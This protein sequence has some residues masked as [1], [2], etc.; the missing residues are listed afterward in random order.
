MFSKFFMILF[1][2]IDIL[3]SPIYPRKLS[4]HDSALLFDECDS[5]HSFNYTEEVLREALT[6]AALPAIGG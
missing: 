5:R 4:L 1:F 6:L 3:P 2:C